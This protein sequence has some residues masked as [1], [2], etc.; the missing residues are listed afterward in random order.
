[1]LLSPESWLEFLD[2]IISVC[3]V[4]LMTEMYAGDGCEI[5]SVYQ[6]YLAIVCTHSSE[7]SDCLVLISDMTMA[8]P[9]IILLTL[10]S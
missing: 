8:P 1:M 9:T 5:R 4:V 6:Q 2:L 3:S 10:E 7:A